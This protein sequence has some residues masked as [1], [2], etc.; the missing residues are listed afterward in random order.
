MLREILSWMPV[1]PAVVLVVSDFRLRTVPVAALVAFGGL[2]VASALSVTS[3]G[4]VLRRTGQNALLLAYLGSGCCLYLSLRYRRRIN[5]LRGYFGTGDLCF[6]LALSP[7]L[8]FREYLYF[9]VGGCALTLCGWAAY[10]G[11]GGCRDTIPLAGTL[12]ILF[13]LHIAMT[14]LWLR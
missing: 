2:A 6:L 8:P 12:G 1:L 7:L 5:P 13:I 3:V 11:L 14:N 10:R 4:E 9:L